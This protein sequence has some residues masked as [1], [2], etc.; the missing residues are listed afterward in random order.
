MRTFKLSISIGVFFLG[1]GP[2]FA[3]P[4]KG[5]WIPRSQTLANG[6]IRYDLQVQQGPE[7]GKPNQ[8][9]TAMG[10]ETGILQ[11]GK[12]TAEAGADWVEPTTDDVSN[13]I[14]GNLK[15]SFQNVTEHGWA[16]SVGAMDFAFRD[17]QHDNNLIYSVIE[18]S[19]GP[20]WSVEMGG[21]T[22]QESRIRTASGAMVGIWRKIQGGA[23]DF[24]IEWM[25]GQGKLGYV[26]PGLRV[27]V[28]DGFEAIL[29]Y[30]IA[31][32]RETF[33]NLFLTR[34]MVYF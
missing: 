21:Y 18:A 27:E 30:A 33:R 20:D 12:L 19:V 31:G 14:T 10:L 7:K 4:S 26:V 16:I 15:L 25:S 34:L 24:G 8:N 32:N 28:R 29:G 23:G 9:A 17:G 2:A 22:G 13:G 1:I 3:Y 5:Y 11:W 6:E